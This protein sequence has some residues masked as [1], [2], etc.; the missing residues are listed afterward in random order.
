[1]L[2]FIVPSCCHHSPI[3][4]SSSLLFGLLLL[5]ASTMASITIFSGCV[6]AIGFDSSFSLPRDVLCS[7]VNDNGGLAVNNVN[8]RVTHVC[9]TPQDPFKAKAK[10]LKIPV[11]EDSL[12][13]RKKQ[14]NQ[15]LPVNFVG[16]LFNRYQCI[17]ADLLL[18]VTVTA[19][20]VLKLVPN[21]NRMRSMPRAVVMV[22]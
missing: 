2:C 7:L 8:E 22:V 13:Q 6:I 9:C 11:I 10:A 4:L 18:I 15:S 1:L 19:L 21:A 12:L 5:L 14:L 16:G 20:L 3:T 17:E